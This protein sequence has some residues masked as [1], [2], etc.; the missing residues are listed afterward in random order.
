MSDIEEDKIVE[1]SSGIS[2][3]ETSLINR[4]YYKSHSEYRSIHGDLVDLLHNGGWT[5]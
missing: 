1:V 3:A 2:E 5:I 4:L